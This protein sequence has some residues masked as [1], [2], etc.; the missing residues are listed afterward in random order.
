[1]YFESLWLR[2]AD[3]ATFHQSIV[4]RFNLFVFSHNYF[5]NKQHGHFEKGVLQ[6]KGVCWKQKMKKFPTFTNHFAKHIEYGLQHTKMSVKIF[7]NLF[8][9]C[10]LKL[11]IHQS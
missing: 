6:I 7:F 5:R 11:W 2:M 10:N 1:M 3:W 8:S 4:N 9:I